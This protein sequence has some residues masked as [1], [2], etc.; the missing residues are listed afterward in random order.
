MN[1]IRNA[2]G[3]GTLE[4][5]LILIGILAIAGTGFYVWHSKQL[6]DKNLTAVNS[7]TVTFKAHAVTSFADCQKTP[8]SKILQTYPEQCVTKTGKA[9]T[10]SSQATAQQFLV[11]K[12]WGVR[13]T[14]P[15]ALQDAYYAFPSGQTYAFLG[16]KSLTALSPDCA[17]DKVSLGLIF[18]Q[19]TAEYNTA[20]ADQQTNGK[21]IDNISGDV[22]IGDY[23]YGYTSPQAGCTDGSNAQATA[24]YNI[25]NPRL[26]F[27]EAEKTLEAVPGT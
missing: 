5:I 26:T 24:L 4:T 1:S 21:N 17:P 19:T 25:A 9:F 12:E 14:L 10:D 27:P 15:A 6:I 13:M 8:G 23:Y 11:I 3:F 18:R 7:A 20:L 2:R 16:L 22:H